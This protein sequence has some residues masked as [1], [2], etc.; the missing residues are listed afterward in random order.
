MQKGF[1]AILTVLSLLVFSV[2]LSL[3]MMYLSL[4]AS[5]VSV[6]PAAGEEVLALAQSCA[7]EVLLKLRNNPLYTGEP[8]NL[9]EGTC[10]TSIETTG[11]ES[12][13]QVQATKDTYTR[14]LRL[15]VDREADRLWLR[16][17]QEE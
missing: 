12:V 4:D 3:S 7:E 14:A 11:S 13:L 8:L 15:V 2:S 9:L 16:S 6:A 17:W 1:I 10:A 5:R